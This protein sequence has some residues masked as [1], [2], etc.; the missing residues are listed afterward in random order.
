MCV[1]AP[2]RAVEGDNLGRGGDSRRKGAEKEEKGRAEA[3]NGPKRKSLRQEI[4]REGQGEGRSERE[5]EGVWEE[6]ETKGGEGKG[7]VL[8][9]VRAHV[10]FGEGW[11]GPGLLGS[12]TSSRPSKGGLR[13]AGQRAEPHISLNNPELAVNAAL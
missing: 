7:C 9:C 13:A 12:L 6:T 3:E 1:E 4:R 5:S 8:E 10:C 11:S 2:G